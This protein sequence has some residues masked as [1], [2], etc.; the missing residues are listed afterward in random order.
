MSRAEPVN[1]S[2]GT[3]LQLELVSGNVHY[4]FPVKLLGYQAGESLMVSLPE[5]DQWLRVGDEFIVRVLGETSYA[6]T[7]ELLRVCYEPFGY[8]HLSYPVGVQGAMMRRAPRVEVHEPA[9]NLTMQDG[10][11]AIRV[12]LAD[13]SYSGARLVAEMQL[14]SI[15][16]SFTIDVRSPV[17]HELISLEC[18]IRYVRNDIEKGVYHHGVQFSRLEDEAQLFIDWV[19]RKSMLQVRKHS[20]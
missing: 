18:T 7:S 12:S 2:V 14:G 13:M 10:S 17:T 4:C 19:L 1:L 3:N 9:I 20:A 16:D 5:T 8:M 15:G 11:R 6:F